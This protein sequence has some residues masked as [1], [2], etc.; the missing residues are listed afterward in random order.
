MKTIIEF[1]SEEEEEAKAAIM[2][3]HWKSSY[4]DLKDSIWDSLFRPRHRHGYST[5]IEEA[6][7]LMGRVR[8]NELLDLLEEEYQK[9]I[10]NF[11][12]RE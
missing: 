3:M 11:P 8:A 1:S 6:I 5:E 10:E 2:G 7:N 12:N 4:F 9:A